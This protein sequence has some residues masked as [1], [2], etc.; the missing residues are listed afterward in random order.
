MAFT[1]AALARNRKRTR[2][3]TLVIFALMA[4]VLFGFAGLALDAGHVYLVYRLTQNATDSAALA[5]GKRLGA[6]MRY[7]PLASSTDASGAPQAIHDYAQA[8]GYTTNF[9]TGCDS[10]VAGSFTT[11][12]VDKGTCAGG[13][14]TRVSITSPPPTLTPDCSNVPYNCMQVTITSNVQN[15]LMG[16]LGIP[17]TTVTT[18]ATVL[19]LP[20]GNVATMPASYA[21]YLYQPMY[22]GPP[23]LCS[24]GSVQCFKPA[25]V[26]QRSQLTCL[27]VVDSC[28]TFWSRTGSNPMIAGI[29]GHNIPDGDLAAM[30]SKGPVVLQD[31][32]TFCDPY[33]GT[34]AANTV[35]GLKGFSLQAGSSLYC[36]APPGQTPIAC[37]TSGPGGAPLNQNYGNETSFTAMT[38]A[39]TITAPSNVCGSLVLNGDTVANSGGSGSCN[40]PAADPYL[41]LPGVY[42]SIVVNHGIYEFGP[43]VFTITGTAPQNTKPACPPQCPA[44]LANGID[45]SLEGTASPGADWDL[46]PSGLSPCT[47]TAGIWIT[48]GSLRY[49]A[50]SSGSGESCGDDSGGA[51][52]P[53]A[54]GGDATWVKGAGVTFQFAGPSSGGFVSTNEVS[55]ISLSGPGLGTQP[56]TGGVPILFDMENSSFIHLDANNPG[57]GGG[58]DDGEGASTINS[59]FVG[60]IYQTTSATGGG[61]EINAG[62]G[63]SGSAIRGQVL[64]YTFTTFGIPGTAVSFTSGFG[65]GSGPPPTS[66]G[67]R[68]ETEMYATPAA[69]L[70]APVP[71][72]AGFETLTWHYTD[73]WKLDAYTTYVKIN[74]TTPVYFSQG[75]WNP[76]PNAGVPLPPGGNTPGETTPAYPSAAQ[77]SGNKYTHT[78]TSNNASDWTMKF[79]DASALEINGGWVWGHENAISGANSGSNVD[80]LKYTFPIPAGLQ[81]TITIFMSD[82]DRCGD[83]VTVTVTLNNVGTFNPGLQSAPTVSLEQ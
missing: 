61:V 4:V 5:G 80:T 39:P 68:N 1:V 64:A 27:A 26:P 29:D 40:P 24:N 79:A 13:F 17:T 15:F 3:Q 47:A 52:P 66:T 46:C 76:A 62:I 38:W 51:P 57:G 67:G 44:Q 9:N 20:P 83:W 81:S 2:G 71:A 32:T 63:G 35:V 49:V 75:I 55:S 19:A 21:L 25:S 70:T 18:S 22:S 58:G 41:I 12:W 56:A 28:P 48:H 82:G 59:Q 65:V 53:N 74:N 31:R 37:N 69:T 60:I 11:S 54:G 23:G 77:D 14:T 45:H 7:A 78:S 42:G 72:Q 36:S 30:Q 33:G 6:A 10:A 50:G 73:E 34:C 16:V 8:N 43:G